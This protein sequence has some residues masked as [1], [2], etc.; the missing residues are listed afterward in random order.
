MAQNCKKCQ[1]LFHFAD[2][3]RAVLEKL[4]PSFHGQEFSIPTPALCEDCRKQRRLAFRNDNVL[5]HRQSSLSGKRTLST[6]H[7]DAPFP[8]YTFEE[9]WSDKWD[10]LDYGAEI[11]FSRP[12]FEQFRELR[13]RVPRCAI[14][15]DNFCENCEFSNQLTMSKD[16]YLVV[17]GS[18]NE[19]CFYSYRLNNSRYCADCLFT[20]D[21]ELCFECVDIFGCYNCAHS[22]TISNCRDSAF[23][24]DCQNCHDCFFSTGL[25]NASYCFFNEQLSKADYKQKRDEILLGDRSVVDT[26]RSEFCSFI[27]KAPRKFAALQNVENVTGDNIQNAKN[28][29]MVFDGS[30]LED[31]H[32]CQFVQDTQDSVDLNYGCDQSELHYDV[33]TSGVN[34]DRILF[35]IDTWPNVSDLIYCDS[36]SNG[37]KNSIG[38]VGLRSKQYCILNN[39][40][41]K[42]E[43]ISLAA[44]LLD[45]MTQTGEWG[46]FFP[47]SISPY[48]YNES[49]S[50]QYFPLEKETALNENFRWHDRP[51]KSSTAGG[52]EPPM[53]LQDTEANLVNEVFSCR[54]CGGDYKIISAELEIHRKLDVALSARC[55]NCRH[56]GRFSKRNPRVLWE[57]ECSKC[58]ATVESSY[59]PDQ[60]E[61][62]LCEECYLEYAY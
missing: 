25:R 15:I 2:G 21:S 60:P 4:Q 3:A 42:D 52:N 6:Y 10:P 26:L 57:R 30:N 33:C 38:C 12:F 58:N 51:S 54:E 32:Y 23:L 49:V 35:S 55:P 28:C 13:D 7:S 62:I 44:K 36:C 34:A 5:Y 22:Q 27:L 9:W 45:H 53:I 1:K 11:G 47:A 46:E 56:Q 24:F 17:S 41:S 59:S 48:G 29:T 8:V 61:G 20:I 39:S 16:C 37:T 43:Y 31:V 14:Q 19:K 50:Q 40:Y 18:T